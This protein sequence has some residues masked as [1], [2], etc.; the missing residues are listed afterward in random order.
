MIRLIFANGDVVRLINNAFAYCFKE[1]RLSTTGG[2]VLEHNKYVGKFSNILRMLT[3]KDGDL[4]S[5]FDKAVED[6]LDNIN[7]LK[8]ILINDH[9]EALNKG[10]TKGQLALEHIFRFSKTF[11][12]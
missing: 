10:E 8:Q 2:S 1:T 4:S 3:N 12:K 11:E 9:N 7:I 6:A 5:Y